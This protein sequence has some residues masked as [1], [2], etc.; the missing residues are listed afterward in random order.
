MQIG[1]ISMQNLYSA[2][3]GMH[4]NHSNFPFDVISKSVTDDPYL[5]ESDTIHAVQ[6]I[7]PLEISTRQRRN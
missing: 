1:I 4:P 2:G 7:T 6:I 5:H 3:L